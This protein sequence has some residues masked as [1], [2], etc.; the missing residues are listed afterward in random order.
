M[1]LVYGK[2]ST[3]EIIPVAVDANGYLLATYDNPYF[4][5]PA[6]RNTF[7][8]NLALPAGASFQTIV[9]VPAGEYWRVTT[10]T[11][12]YVGTV[13]GVTI[14]GRGYDGTNSWI[15]FDRNALTST[16]WYPNSFNLILNPAQSFLVQVVGATLND[17]LYVSLL[18]ERIY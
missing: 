17:D 11:I 10:C 13:A 7:F 12:A 2:R 4:L 18:A 1:S 9:T 3:N 6:Q 5:R 15:V 16:Q 14:N 8:S